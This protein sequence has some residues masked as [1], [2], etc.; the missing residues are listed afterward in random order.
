MNEF[1]KAERF[2]CEV[3]KPARYTGGEYG[4]VKKD[5]SGVSV[6]YAYGFPDTYEIGMSNLG[7][8][9]LYG[10]TNSIDGVW[11]ERVFAP[12]PDMEEKMRENGVKLYG[13]ESG[14]AISDFD[15]VSFSLA[16]ELCYTN[17]L[18]MLD[19]A[20]IP[21]LSAE[22]GE[23]DPIILAGGHCT[24]NPEPAA[25]FAD[26]FLIGEGEELNREVVELYRDMKAAGKSR[27]EFLAESVKI[28]GVYVPAFY[29][30]SYGEDGTIAAVEAKCGAPARV[31]KRIIRDMDKAYWPDSYPIPNTEVVHD[32]VMTEVFRGCTRG[33]RFCQAGHVTRPIREKSPDTVVEQTI[34]HLEFSGGE[35]VS[36]TSLSTSDYRGLQEACDKLI[37]YCEPRSISISLPSLRADSVSMALLERVSKVR[38]SGLTFAPEAGSQRLRDVINKNLSE[39]EIESAC[40]N[41]F[42]SGW[43]SVKLYF[44][45]G[46][47]TE[48]EEDIEG[49]ADLANR[50]VFLWR[51]NAQNKNRGL[52]ITVSTSSF[53]PKPGTPFQWFGQNTKEQLEAKIAFLKEKMTAKAVTYNWH[54]PE[55]SCLEGIFARGDRRLGAAILEAWKRGAKFD[56][57]D[58]YFDYSRWMDCFAACGIDP[59]W[60][61]ARQRGM[62]E[63]LPWDHIDTG[64]TRRFLARGWEAA[65]RGETLPECSAR[66]GGCGADRLKGGKCDV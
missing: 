5:L 17:M 11:C 9:I 59:A 19:L 60:Y 61:N 30:V 33:C 46:L 57:W 4:E 10:L 56:G 26:I 7:L 38:K 31:E 43:N 22:R 3:Q 54:E 50:L 27:A 13:L 49:I 8:R 24:F 15:M 44:M 32:R 36:L 37:A 2:L 23:G 12:W 21:L 39:E 62:D 28:P 52:K 64:V 42:A 35:E 53:V 1:Q 16:Y 66:C 45:L 29:D 51:Q 48:T 25:D 65:L 55:V 20:G 18:N 58:D 63:I 6:R 34:R 41:A 14:D 47:P 40:T